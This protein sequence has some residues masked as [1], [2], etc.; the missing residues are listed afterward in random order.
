MHYEEAE[1][2]A[3]ACPSWLIEYSD[4]HKENKN[5]AGAKRLL[6]LVDDEKHPGI[7]DVFRAIL[8]SVRL[9]AAT[10]RVFELYM[11]HPLNLNIVFEHAIIDWT[12]SSRG[13]GYEK[14][15]VNLGSIAE[16]DWRASPD[17]SVASNVYF[18]G[19]GDY[20]FPYSVLPLGK[21]EFADKAREKFHVNASV[22]STDISCIFRYL[23]K[24]SAR[25]TA[26]VDDEVK[27]VLADFASTSANGTVFSA[28]HIRDYGRN[29]IGENDTQTEIPIFGDSLYNLLGSLYCAKKWKMP[30][31]LLASNQMLR[32]AAEKKLFENVRGV[33]GLAV[34]SSF[35][36]AGELHFGT[37]VEIGLLARARCR[38]LTRSG[39]G[40]IGHWLS[41]NADCVRLVGDRHEYAYEQRLCQDSLQ[42]EERR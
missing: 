4:F 13:E 27:S 29:M 5:N 19:S 36:H 3:T 20:P 16:A 40:Y 2:N 17:G 34:H 10:D 22:E 41:G 7:G 15:K 11:T 21:G 42:F 24:E 28:I 14:M 31:I 32:I 23:F 25:L 8:W 12:T 39:F 38:I 35:S 9:A 30:T 37:F 33:R 1:W 18:K 26:S 6:W